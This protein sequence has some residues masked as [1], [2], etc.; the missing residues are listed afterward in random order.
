MQFVLEYSEMLRI[1]TLSSLLQPFP[2]PHSRKTMASQEEKLYEDE[3]FSP[4]HVLLPEF[5]LWWENSVTKMETIKG[6]CLHPR[7][8]WL[9]TTDILL[10]VSG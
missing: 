5:G 9:N 4:I 3:P 8:M 1:N 10:P 6:V 2:H 7:A